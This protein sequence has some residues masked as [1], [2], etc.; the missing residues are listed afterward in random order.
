[1][2][3]NINLFLL[4]QSTTGFLVNFTI[5]LFLICSE[6]HKHQK[7]G[8]FL[9]SKVENKVASMDFPFRLHFLGENPSSFWK[10]SKWK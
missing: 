10:A 9:I 5:I 6:R 8:E 2:T 4:K 1:M 3:L 7:A